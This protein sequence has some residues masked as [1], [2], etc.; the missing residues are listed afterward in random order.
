M[1]AGQRRATIDT[2]NS[3]LSELHAPAASDRTNGRSV[4]ASPV[5]SCRVLERYC[6]R[7]VGLE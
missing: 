5:A 4:N 2:G 7:V 6:D 3:T 1:H